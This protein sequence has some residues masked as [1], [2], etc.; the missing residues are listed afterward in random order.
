MLCT[1]FTDPSTVLS[2][3]PISCTIFSSQIF[4]LINVCVESLQF[5]VRLVTIVT[6][7]LNDQLDTYH[8]PENFWSRS[9]TEWFID[10]AHTHARDKS[11]TCPTVCL[12]EITVRC[13]NFIY[14]Y[15][16][17]DRNGTEQLF[18][19]V[20]NAYLSLRSVFL[21]FFFFKYEC[22]FLTRWLKPF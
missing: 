14:R 13:I 10:L 22:T 17:H 16:I 2:A 12:I 3:N 9:K 11:N 6:Q 8:T 4:H 19:W 20:Q 7:D 1:F 18:L 5:M 21:F 15:I